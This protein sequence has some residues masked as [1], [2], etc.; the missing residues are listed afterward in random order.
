MVKVIHCTACRGDALCIVVMDGTYVYL[1]ER[2]ERERKQGPCTILHDGAL[3]T[4][5]VPCT[6]W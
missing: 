3:H 5:V 2:G 6:L 4:V 1:L